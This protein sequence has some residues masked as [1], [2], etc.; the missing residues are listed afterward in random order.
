VTWKRKQKLNAKTLL[1]Q[2]QRALELVQKPDDVVAVIVR[3]DTL[4]KMKAKG[5]VKCEPGR[6]S[7]AGVQV[8]ERSG[9]TS[10][11]LYL[12]RDGSVKVPD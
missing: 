5:M 8:I 12:C 10:P 2:M 6:M 4:V 7:S 1:E 3:P 9:L 11:Y